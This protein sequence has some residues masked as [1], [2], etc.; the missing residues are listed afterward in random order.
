MQSRPTLTSRATLVKISQTRQTKM[1]SH[2]RPEFFTRTRGHNTWHVVA[3]GY[4]GTRPVPHC[5]PDTLDIY[6]T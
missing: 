5:D 4:T 2:D 1:N 3:H 6:S